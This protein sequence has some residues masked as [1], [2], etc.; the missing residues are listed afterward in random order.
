MSEAAVNYLQEKAD[1]LQDKI[2]KIKF[3]M[4]IIICTLVIAAIGYILTWY[5]SYQE[6][7]SLKTNFLLSVIIFL[8]SIL[9][10][11]N[12]RS[13]FFMKVIK[14]QNAML[15]FVKEAIEYPQDT[16]KVVFHGEK[17]NEKK[18]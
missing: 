18:T 6:V 11:N 14:A 10:I 2:K 16:K 7:I 12:E 8:C 15:D 13:K 1:D 4:K 5:L 9:V 3:N 17:K